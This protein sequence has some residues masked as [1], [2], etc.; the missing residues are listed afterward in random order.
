MFLICYLLITI[1][2]NSSV[3]MD[4]KEESIENNLVYINFTSLNSIF[5]TTVNNDGMW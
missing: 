1:I 5:F 2:R 4:G 3:E